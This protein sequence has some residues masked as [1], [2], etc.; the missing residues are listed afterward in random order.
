MSAQDTSSNPE[1]HPRKKLKPIKR[2][3]NGDR[4]KKES[5]S[6]SRTRNGIRKALK[7]LDKI[8]EKKE[9]KLALKRI[10]VEVL[11]IEGVANYLHCSV[12]TARNVPASELPRAQKPGRRNLY[13]RED[14]DEYVRRNKNQVQNRDKDSIG[15]QRLIDSEADNVRGRS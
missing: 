11:A 10:D 13:M 15:S 14:I 2:S 3:Q 9:A 8:R 7:R 12:Q 1:R 4:V 6:K 5:R